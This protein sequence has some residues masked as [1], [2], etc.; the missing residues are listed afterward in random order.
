MVETDAFLLFDRSL[1]L[2]HASAAAQRL[3][4]LNPC[5]AGKPL[6][7]LLAGPA[8]LRIEEE[9][10]RS[11]EQQQVAT[12][13]YSSEEPR[14]AFQLSV[15][16][17]SE[18]F[19]L[20]AMSSNVSQPLT[21]AAPADHAPPLPS[22]LRR[23]H[24]LNQQLATAPDLLGVL[25]TA[26]CAALEMQH[27]EMGLLSL[28]A[29]D[30]PGLNAAV[31]Q[32]FT[33]TF[34]KLVQF[35][36]PGSGVCG[37]AYELRHPVIV[38]DIERDRAYDS[39]RYVAQ[40]GGFRAVHST[41]LIAPGGEVV[42]VLSTFFSQPHRPALEEI[43][44]MDLYGLQVAELIQKAQRS[45]SSSPTGLLLDPCSAHPWALSQGRVA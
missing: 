40:A 42:G 38:E 11:L 16:P 10:R 1:R 4:N 24:E 15:Y 32:G 19:S 41:P 45:P 27:T 37:Q 5:D 18:G 29:P 39:Y 12:L 44:L 22:D 7:A 30:R 21:V 36:L 43:H 6:S 9:C 17:S 31:H 23:L 35:V 14:H 26:L 13:Q 25:R 8:G 28:A 33:G 3:F 34:L 2:V 20:W